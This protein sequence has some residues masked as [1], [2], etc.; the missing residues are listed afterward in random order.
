MTNEKPFSG[1]LICTDFDGTLSADSGIPQRNIDAILDFCQKGGLFTIS[2]GRDHQFLERKVGGLF[3]SPLIC[4]NGTRIYDAQ[5]GQVIFSQGMSDDAL[6]SL[7]S[8]MPDSCLGIE[9]VLEGEPSRGFISPAEFKISDYEGKSIAKIVTMYQTREENLKARDILTA[10]FPEYTFGRS[11]SVGLEQI[12]PLAGKGKCLE[13]LKA[14]LGAKLT[15]GVGDFENDLSMLRQ[16]DIACAPSN[17]IGEIKEIA[18]YVLCS[19]EEGA[20]AD[21]IE[22]LPDILKQIV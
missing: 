2:S 4:V 21:L 13:I 7:K 8:Y 10:L 9:V 5:N 15:I 18:D 3:N 12:S 17:A 1:I 19:A 22:K 11:F 6:R 20:L 14:H 16:A